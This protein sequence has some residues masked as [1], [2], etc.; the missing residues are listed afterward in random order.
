MTRTASWIWAARAIALAALG[1][2]LWVFAANWSTAREFMSPRG[3]AVGI[4]WG[5][6]AYALLSVLLVIAW[7]WLCGGY[8]T[9]PRMRDAY[10]VWA[11]AQFAKYLPGNVLHFVG[12][13]TLGRRTGTSQ[14][15]LL[16][17]SVMETFGLLLAASVIVLPPAMSMGTAAVGLLVL[18][19]S[20]RWLRR[21]P[22]IGSR[23]AELPRLQPRR[24]PGL[25]L[26]P[27]LLY[28]VFLLANG[29]I[30][31]G[32]A[33]GGWPEIDLDP[34]GLIRAFAV[35]WLAGTLTPG[36]SGGIGVREAVLTL[37]LG[38]VMGHGNVAAL[39]ILLRSVTVGGDL[40]TAFAGWRQPLPETGSGPESASEL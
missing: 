3:L 24:L 27:F 21:L 39:A 22:L 35:A 34:A 15:A 38:P 4:G 26:P 33:S 32:L 10:A 8:A 16:W 28:L 25:L 2:V 14:A 37:E 6:P 11:R 40:L 12:R 19:V 30:L 5:A 9:R 36:A 7:R 18:L 1:W 13:Q 23:L 17:A 29:L 31:F 20:D